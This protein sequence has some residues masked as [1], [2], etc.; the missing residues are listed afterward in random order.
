MPMAWAFTRIW[1]KGVWR[2][3]KSVDEV[4]S[5]RFFI[6]YTLKMD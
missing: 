1:C 3:L 6:V 2:Y 4:N 5:P